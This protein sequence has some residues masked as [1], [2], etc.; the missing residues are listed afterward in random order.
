MTEMLRIVH[1]EGGGGGIMIGVLEFK[2]LLIVL[3]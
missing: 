3:R 2:I 1:E